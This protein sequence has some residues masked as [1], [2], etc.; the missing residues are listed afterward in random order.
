M[1]ITGP[2]GKEV[3]LELTSGKGALIFSLTGGGALFFPNVVRMAF[4]NSEFGKM[5]AE[6]TPALNITD[7]T[8]TI[9]SYLPPNSEYNLV[10][11]NSKIPYQFL[12]NMEPPASGQT[13]PIHLS[14]YEQTQDVS[15]GKHF[16]LKYFKFNY[17]SREGTCHIYLKASGVYDDDFDFEEV[18]LHYDHPPKNPTSDSAD[19]EIGGTLRVSAYG[20]E[21][22]GLEVDY[23]KENEEKIF[24]FYYD[25]QGSKPI[26]HT[27][28]FALNH[29][30]LL[31]DLIKPTTEKKELA[32]I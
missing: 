1:K 18:S 17:G 29:L 27:D 15:K 19:W 9:G 16:G 22:V 30:E 24:R 13:I 12:I 14:T 32:T 25:D 4:L 26:L 2:S 20:S 23:L 11:N 8:V 3:T 10:R 21:E 7:L 5:M 31:I 6:I 28:N